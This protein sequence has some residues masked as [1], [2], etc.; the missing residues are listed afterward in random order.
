MASAAQVPVLT[1]P[2]VDFSRA[3]VLVLFN[4]ADE[5]RV[6]AIA[7]EL[8]LQAAKVNFPT[9]AKDFLNAV[10]FSMST[11]VA[12]GQVRCD[13]TLPCSRV[14]LSTHFVSSSK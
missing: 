2:F 4:P 14:R 6:V 7:T 3:G 10:R 1:T 11:A 12:L 5:L 9:V 8:R 13:L